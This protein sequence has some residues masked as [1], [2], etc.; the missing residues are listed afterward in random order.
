MFLFLSISGVPSGW[1]IV[2]RNWYSVL[3]ASMAIVFPFRSEISI[4][5]LGMIS[6][7]WVPIVFLG[8]GG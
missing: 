5:F 3:N 4:C 7:I 1:R 2:V 6:P 8:E